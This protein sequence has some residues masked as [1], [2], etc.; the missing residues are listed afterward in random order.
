MKL[1]LAA[2]M[3]ALPAAAAFGQG[4]GWYERAVKSVDVAFEPAKA[5]P[6][7]TVIFRLTVDLHDGFHT[8]PTVQPDKNAATMVNRIVFPDPGIVIF[9]GDV[10]DPP[11][12][13]LKAEP[14]LGIKELR[15][16]KGTVVFER[17]AVVS[18]RA[19]AGKSG[20]RLKS[21][22]LNVCDADNCFPPKPLE[23]EAAINV[24]GEPMAVDKAW[25]AEVE[26]A[27]PGK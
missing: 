12:P 14:L 23:P 25:A 1:L 26:K 3:L 19:A 11:M 2:S 17:T 18:P 24:A 10:R 21:F 13:D 5:R 8:Y 22:R 16:H 7:Q 20:V 6:G 4:E 9:V 27:M 15:T